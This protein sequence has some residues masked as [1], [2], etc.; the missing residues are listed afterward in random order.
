VKEFFK[1]DF[2]KSLKKKTIIYI[3]YKG[4]INLEQPEQQPSCDLY[5]IAIYLIKTELILLF[6]YREYENVFSKKGC[7]II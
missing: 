2:K 4:P 1:K 7:E 5:K 3:F 6:K